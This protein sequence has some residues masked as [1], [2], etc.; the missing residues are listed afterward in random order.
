MA[1]CGYMVQAGETADYEFKRQSG[2]TSYKLM[3]D[4]EQRWREKTGG[5][6]YVC[7]HASNSYPPSQ[8]YYM[9]VR[10]KRGAAGPVPPQVKFRQ[11]MLYAG[12]TKADALMAVKK[13]TFG[14]AWKD[15]PDTG[16]YTV[17]EQGP[18]FNAAN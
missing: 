12:K 17:I 9:L 1:V 4:M 16:F 8:Y 2:T 11:V 18:Y 6:G 5:F 10:E 14:V 15:A 3:K 7:T 13:G